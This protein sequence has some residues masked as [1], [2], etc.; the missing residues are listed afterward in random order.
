[1]SKK[2]PKKWYKIST[3]HKDRPTGAG[4]HDPRPNR[5]RERGQAE[6]KAIEDQKEE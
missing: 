5:E 4:P 2:K 3:G 6:R 1:M